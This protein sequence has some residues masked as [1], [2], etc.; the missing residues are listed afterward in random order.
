MP[1][2]K[3]S[4]MNV[5]PLSCAENLIVGLAPGYID[6]PTIS[7]VIEHPDHGDVLRDTGIFP[8]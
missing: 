8:L 3:V 1:S 5:G 4:A 6:M 7:V 2:L